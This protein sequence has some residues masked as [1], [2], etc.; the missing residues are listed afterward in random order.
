MTIT[1]FTYPVHTLV[2]YVIQHISYL[3]NN[4]YIGIRYLYKKKIQII[5]SKYL[6]NFLLLLDL[7]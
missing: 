6:N 4:Y 2:K 5:R 1:L 7:V 3:K